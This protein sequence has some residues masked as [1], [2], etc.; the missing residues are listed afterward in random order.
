MKNYIGHRNLTIQDK[1]KNISFPLLL[2]YPSDSSSKEVNLGPFTINSTSEASILDGEF[3][4]VI[5]SHGTGGTHL[6]YLT[7]A[8]HLVEHGYV[9]AM[10]EHYGN[11]RNNNDLEG[12]LENLEVRPRHIS[13][14]IDFLWS[15]LLLKSHLNN[16]VALI[17]HSMGGYTALAVAGG[18][19]WSEKKEKVRVVPDKRLNALVLLAPATEWYTPEASLKN[20]TLPILMLTAEHDQPL[21]SGWHKRTS[22]LVLNQIQDKK[23]ISFRVVENS[24]HFSFL[25]PFPQVMHSPN[26]L[27]STDPDGFDREKFHKILN[28]E[29]F[30]FLKNVL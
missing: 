7:I 18:E 6:G 17:G 30:E 3:P 9:V 19:P 2:M 15:D 14:A 1:E 24:G 10:P 4:L 29:I 8:Q 23:Q 27:P 28:I 21:P 16:K 13:L 20:V 22:G 12:T 11:N 25:S 5:I 26:F